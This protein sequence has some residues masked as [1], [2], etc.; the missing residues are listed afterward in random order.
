MLGCQ[1]M[2][3]YFYKK[4]GKLKQGYWGIKVLL[5]TV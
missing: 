1:E 2:G 3:W 5:Y 4:C